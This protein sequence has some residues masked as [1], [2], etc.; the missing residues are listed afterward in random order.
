VHAHARA[1]LERASREHGHVHVGAPGHGQR[2]GGG[3]HT[4]PGHVR[5]LETGQ[6]HRDPFA[7]ARPVAAAPVYVETADLD[8]PAGRK[9]CQVVIDRHGAAD[10]RA[11]D[12]GAES[13]HREHPI[14]RQPRR[15]AVAP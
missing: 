14:D 9:E 12:D 2:I 4:A 6:V 1:V 11:G 8:P 3:E 10:Q 13:P 5:D 15:P 7:G